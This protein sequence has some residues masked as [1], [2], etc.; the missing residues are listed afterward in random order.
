MRLLLQPTRHFEEVHVKHPAH[1]PSGLTHHLT[2]PQ[3]SLYYNL[4]VAATRYP[5]KTALN[6]YG[7]ETSYAQ[8]RREVDPLA[9][10]LANQCGVAPGERVV[11]Y[12]QN[13]PQFV[14]GFYAILRANAVVV[15]V[16]PV[17]LAADLRYSPLI[18]VQPA[19]SCSVARR[20]SKATGDDPTPRATRSS[21]SPASA[22]FAPAISD[23]STKTA[24]S[25]WSTGSSG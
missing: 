15:P 4:E 14:I 20:S 22:T 24:T 16:N 10:F 21:N 12:M 1:W 9:G 5:R 19:K 13:S 2:A 3:T 17:S 8:L 11:L 25:S 7:A 18:R 23:T 6:Y